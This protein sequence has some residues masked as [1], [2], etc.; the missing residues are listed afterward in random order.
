MIGDPDPFG[1]VCSGSEQAQMGGKNIG[2]LLNA[3]GITW[4][5]FAGGFNLNLVN[6]DGSTGCNRQS[7]SSDRRYAGRL[8]S[9]SHSVPVL[10]FHRESYACAPQVDCRRLV[11]QAILPTTTMISTIFSPRF[12]A[13]N[14]PQVSFLKAIS[15]QDAHP[16][17]SDPSG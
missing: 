11:I 14:F 9:P 6:P 8:C 2:D 15:I 7:T 16:G 12:Q 10:R 13:G 1:D 4:G 17:N 5:W 3:A